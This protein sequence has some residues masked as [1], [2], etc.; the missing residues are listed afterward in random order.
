[1]WILDHNTIITCFPK[2]YGVDHDLSGV[3][4]AVR[5]RLREVRH[6][7]SVFDIAL[8]VLDECSNTFF[9]RMKDA[10][11]QP[12]VLDAFSEA[13]KNVKQKQSDQFEKLWDWINQSRKV[14]RQERYDPDLRAPTFDPGEEGELD[15]EVED[16]VEEL[17]MMISISKTHLEICEKFIKQARKMLEPGDSEDLNAKAAND[18]FS[19]DSKDLNAKA[20]YDQFS[21]NSDQLTFNVKDRISYLEELLRNAKGAAVLAGALSPETS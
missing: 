18:R 4:E 15:K 2:R 7:R 21:S 1:M 17:E 13:I 11:E 12:R 8:I 19:S 6:F 16:I 10:T 5:M 20:A 14:N 9:S 3:N